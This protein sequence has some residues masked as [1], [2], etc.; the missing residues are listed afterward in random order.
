MTT[1]GERNTIKIGDVLK[2][3]RTGNTY[4]VVDSKTSNWTGSVVYTLTCRETKEQ[5]TIANYALHS[6]FNVVGK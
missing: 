6:K 1:G 2:G 5:R 4:D 3:K